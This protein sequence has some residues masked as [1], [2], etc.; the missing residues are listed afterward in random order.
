MFSTLLVHFKH[1][2]ECSG[3]I[4]TLPVMALIYLVVT[5]RKTLPPPL[6]S[7]CRATDKDTMERTASIRLSS[8]RKGVDPIDD[9]RTNH[10]TE[11]KSNV[12]MADTQLYNCS[13]EGGRRGVVL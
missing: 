4:E 12:F 10:R 11:G 6:L 13:S 5:A 9:F 2:A 7:L 8:R 1:G 3:P